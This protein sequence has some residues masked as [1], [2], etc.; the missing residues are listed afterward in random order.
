MK[1]RLVVKI[2][3]RIKRWLHN[4]ILSKN[5][6]IIPI[7]EQIDNLKTLDPDYFA[8]LVRH[9][10]VEPFSTLMIPTYQNNK[11]VLFSVVI[12]VYNTSP[13]LLEKA[14]RS[15]MTQIYSNWGI[16]ICNDASDST[17]TLEYL[18]HL[19]DNFGG[20][21]NIT[22]IT[23]KQ[24]SGISESTNACVEQSKGDFILFLDHDD[25]LYP[26]A[27][28]KLNQAIDL[29]PNAALFYSD[30][31]YIS[32]DGYRHSYNF[33]PNFSPSLLES[34]NYILHLMCI[35]K[36]IFIKAGML[37]KEF[38]GSQ[39]YDLLLRL[40]DMGEKFVHVQ[41]IL[42]S[43]R[44]NETSMLGGMLK[45]EIFQTG[46]KALE[47]HYKRRGDNV[48]YINDYLENIRGFYRA[49][50][51][52]PD[53]I[54]ILI[55]QICT[56][57]LQF[58]PYEP[59][60][61]TALSIKQSIDI[62][63]TIWN[64][65][66]PFPMQIAD[67]DSDVVIFLDS[68]LTPHSWEEFLKETV[69]LALR[70]H[71][72]AVGA[73]IYS[74]D[75]K[76]I[77]A[78]RSL[79]PWGE[80]RN[81][82][83]GYDSGE[84]NSHAKRTRDVISVSGAA[85]VISSKKLKN[86][87]N[88]GGLDQAMWD[89]EICLRLN[90]QINGIINNSN[91]NNSFNCYSR[92]VF[93]PNAFLLYKGTIE[94][95][96]G[97]S[98]FNVKHL[99]DKYNISQ[100]PYLN[101]NL[102]DTPNHEGSDKRIS[103][104]PYF[105]KKSFKISEKEAE[106]IAFEKKKRDDFYHKWIALYSL[107]LKK[108]PQRVANLEY[109]PLFSIILPTYNS[110]LIFFKELIQSLQSQTYKYFEI[111][112]SDD[113]SKNRDFLE[114]LDELKAESDNINVVR[115]EKNRGIAGNTN[116]AI[117]IAKGEWFILCDHDDLVEPFALEMIAQYINDNPDVDVLYSDE[118]MIDQKGWRHSPRLQPD[119][120]P[121]ML[122]SH[123]YCP[124]IVSFKREVL[125]KICKPSLSEQNNIDSISLHGVQATVST[126]SPFNPD[127]DGAQD[128]DFFLRLTEKANNVG[129]IPQI[130]YSWRSVQGSVAL[131]ACA[132]IYAYDAGKRALEAAI[133]RREE[134]AVVL[135]AAGT[136]L[137]V[138]RVKRRVK[139]SS[140]THI[141]EGGSNH[142]VSMINN[143]RNISNFPV[144]IIVVCREG[145]RD[146]FDNLTIQSEA[147]IVTC[148]KDATLSEIYNT[149]A[150]Y[151]NEEYLIFSS[152]YIDLL[153]S[154]YP[155][156]LIEHTQ[157]DEI[158]AVGVKIIYPN[159]FYYHTGMIL[160]VN[161]VRGYAHRNIWQSPGHWNFAACI[162]NYSAV[163]WDFMGVAREKF[164]E[165]E[166][167]DSELNQLGD[168]DFCLK[169]VKKG[170]K[171]LYTPY[172]S[173]VLNRSVHFLEELRDKNEE[174]I[175]IKRHGAFINSGDPMYHPLMSKTVEDFSI[176]L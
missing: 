171:N 55:V 68:Q 19:K 147:K 95:Y 14:V 132:K 158:G 65:S 36:E 42:Y 97:S 50:F 157:R 86:V 105:E 28:L 113:A 43:W 60:S 56:S 93:N 155:F 152:K 165:I 91:I 173:A 63:L 156:G 54:S 32:S 39:D 116:Q 174:D 77:A 1:N 83:F 15:V 38:D 24:N 66:D 47:E 40:M 53:N 131:D 163:S 9:K 35:K 107:N 143:I 115:S 67:T 23:N 34:H 176:T 13:A 5:R 29:N 128:Y 12:P 76:I 7:S 84:K 166:G 57:S 114:F 21:Q 102:I 90:R 16:V 78:G 49:R 118:D 121:D 109:K 160:G 82:F 45:P 134:D 25:E 2:L 8:W 145:E 10:L 87:L 104:P 30:E 170:Y 139:K 4:L 138:Y 148:Q 120:N 142:V 124:H 27:L 89:V 37:R 133:K 135:K 140:V 164:D 151:S 22:I 129:H 61:S 150:S 59:L 159:G 74:G 6:W 70:D 79:M 144:E 137:G 117:A 58:N 81:D 123:M 126:L 3:N 71:I 75:D 11:N 52:M 51:L 73:L 146:L 127:M 72:G 20:T 103:I 31:D 18:E 169:L 154:D 26:D 141:I 92:I 130:L 161:G 175:I 162:R 168:V 17:E 100:D 88:E 48:E 119:W 125:N 172:I 112:I 106:Q 33:K 99:A 136:G 44:E 98:M 122:L 46:K 80:M 62:K 85:M 167:F 149:G 41:D 64:P 101:L 111:C 96:H 110:E 108:S 94:K 153:D 69:P